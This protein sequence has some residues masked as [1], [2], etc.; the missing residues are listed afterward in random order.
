MTPT[1]FPRTDHKE[2]MPARASHKI[3]THTMMFFSRQQVLVWLILFLGSQ[4]FTVPVTTKNTAVR[5][6]SLAPRHHAVVHPTALFLASLHPPEPSTE[7]NHHH[8]LVVTG[9]FLL[10]LL[11]ALAK[12][13]PLQE[14]FTRHTP[15]LQSSSH[16][17]SKL[18][19][20]PT[21]GFGFG[22]LGVG[23]GFMPMPFGG[24]GMGFT[25][26]N[27]P[28]PPTA[29]QSL[30]AHQQEL[31]AVKEYEKNLEA[32][33]KVMEQQQQQQHHQTSL[34]P[35]CQVN[36]LSTSCIAVVQDDH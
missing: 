5:A 8:T 12:P 2:A 14:A 6:T 25:V 21:P 7:D 20:R 29:A 23:P 35:F 19:V 22:G 9:A 33:I 28:E 24:F 17:I 15:P 30:Q 3:T 1:A 32:R 4:A 26:R 18:E 11:V 27:R 10:A 31:Q 34:E 36:H 16:I 13:L